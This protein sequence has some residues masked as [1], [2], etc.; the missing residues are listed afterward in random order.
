MIKIFQ[1]T[2]IVGLGVALAM[3]MVFLPMHDF[4]RALAQTA[5]SETP[6]GGQRVYT[7]TC[8]CSGN[9][10]LYI[11][12]YRTNTILTLLYQ[13]GASIL[14]SY[15]NVYTSTYLLGTYSSTGNSCKIYVGEDCVDI[16]N[17]G[18]LGSQPGTG[19]SQN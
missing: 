13:E 12:D 6:Y 14:Y 5:S 8:D 17:E 2:S 18:Q 10:L 19:T 7:L 16:S 15:Y 4:S 1:A 3:A 9:A 11:M